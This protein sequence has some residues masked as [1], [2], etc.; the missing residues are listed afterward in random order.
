MSIRVFTKKA[1]SILLVS[2]LVFG[3]TD[4]LGFS[5]TKQAFAVGSFAK[6]GVASSYYANNDLS[7]IT[8]FNGSWF[9][10]WGNSYSADPSRIGGLEYVPMLWGAGSVTTANLDALK[11]GKAAGKF[12][13]LLAFNE[14]DLAEQSNMTVQQCIDLWPKLMNTGLRL[15]S[16][17]TT[18]PTNGWLDSFMAEANKRG[19]RV[20]FIAL[21]FYPDFTNP[22]SVNDIKTKIT[23]V[24]NKYKK[25]IWVTEIGTVDINAWGIPT[26]A[27]PTQQAADEY[28]KKVIPMLESLSFV[29]RYAWFADRCYDNQVTKYSSLYDASGSLTNMGKIYQ[30]DSAPAVTFYE[31][32]DYGKTAKS[33]PLGTYTLAQMNAA[34][35]P[36]NWMSSLKVPKGYT[37][38]V[39]DNDNFT[40]A[41]WTFTADTSYVGANCNDRMTSVK[42]LAAVFCEHADY[43]GVSIPLSKGNYTMAQ[44]N[45]AG[46]SNDWI[47]SLRVPGGWIVEL[48][49]N[50]NFTGTKWTFTADSNYVGAAANDK[51]TSIKIY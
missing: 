24:Y 43:K 38:E 21:H 36:D 12:K 45:A 46:I 34:G 15:G 1:F 27:A 26:K 40:G 28:M 32:A 14:P 29:E 37:V 30:S 44:I 19:Y 39:Y 41:K 23:N 49:E 22:D 20:D 10:N 4:F 6:K 2:L 33:L 3:Q 48:Y 11:Q 5:D 50:D 51:A 42:V 25:P 18:T 17:A 7:K 13:N 8:A 9:Y 35:I 47:S 16:P 31:D